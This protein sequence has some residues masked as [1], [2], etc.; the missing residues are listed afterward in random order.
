M[1]FIKVNCIDISR[2]SFLRTGLIPR[3]TM[4]VCLGEEGGGGGA[5][6]G[7]GL[8][9]GEVERCICTHSSRGSSM[10]PSPSQLLI[11]NS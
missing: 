1:V 10:H 7:R 11:V 5:R 3:Q 4:K 8:V 6:R 9:G 2:V